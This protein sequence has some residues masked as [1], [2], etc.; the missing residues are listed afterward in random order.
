MNQ[1]IYCILI[2]YNQFFDEINRLQ[3][4]SDQITTN[5]CISPNVFSPFTNI[6]VQQAVV[7]SKHIAFLLQVENFYLF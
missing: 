6:V 5:G 3:D 2:Y 7:S 4:I 1:S